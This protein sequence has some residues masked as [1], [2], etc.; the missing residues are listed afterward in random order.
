MTYDYAYVEDKLTSIT[1]RYVSSSFYSTADFDFIQGDS[2]AVTYTAANGN[3]F[4]YKFH[5]VNNNI[6]AAKTTRGSQLCSQ[7]TFAYD[8]NQNPFHALGY[9]DFYLI[10]YSENNKV[11]ESVQYLG[12]SFPDLVPESYEY[13]YNAAKYPLTSTTTYSTSGQVA[14][15][16][17]KSFTYQEF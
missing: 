7:G 3:S 5:L 13:E 1:E 2:V 16:S 17:R 6:T 12:C 8:K 9:I 15:K 10:N 4:I 11:S 14:P